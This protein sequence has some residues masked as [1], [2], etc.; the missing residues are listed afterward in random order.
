MLIVAKFPGKCSV[1]GKRIEAGSRMHW[2]GKGQP[3]SHEA[4]SAAQAPQGDAVATSQEP[5][6]ERSP[7]YVGR[8]KAAE[9]PAWLLSE[10]CPF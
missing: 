4:C 7:D 9:D 8:L 6:D 2:T 10:E 3:T 1:C 5:R